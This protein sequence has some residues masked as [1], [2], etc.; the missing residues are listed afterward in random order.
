MK[1]KQAE[2]TNLHG[3]DSYEPHPLSGHLL[4]VLL[5]LGPPT[6]YAYNTMLA[7]YG[8]RPPAILFD[9]GHAE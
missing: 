3:H 5:R 2:S 7:S 1:D 8:R 4:P 9:L 6:G